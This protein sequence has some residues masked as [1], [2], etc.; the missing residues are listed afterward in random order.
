ML[1]DELYINEQKFYAVRLA[2]THVSYSRDYITRLAREGKVKAVN[3]GRIWYIHVDSLQHYVE[4]QALE[5]DIRNR[6][7]KQERK[8]EHTVREA[9]VNHQE[10][11]FYTQRRL[12]AFAV[13]SV[14]V[15]VVLGFAAGAGIGTLDMIAAIPASESA[16]RGAQFDVTND[17]D[18]LIPVF[19]TTTD[20]VTVAADREILK[21]NT[22]KDWLRIRYD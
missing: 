1:K 3:M 16:D 9:M 11:T 2:A 17:Q 15:V 4:I 13:V 7:L 6:L 19:T 5:S 12:V 8:I 14:C 22:E 18:V 21:P 10:A 20:A